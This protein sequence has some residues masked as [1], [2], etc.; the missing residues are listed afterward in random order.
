MLL[1]NNGMQTD[2]YDQ[3]NDNVAENTITYT[4]DTRNTAENTKRTT[5]NKNKRRKCG[6]IKVERCIKKP[7]F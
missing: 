7:S 3:N 4:T 1:N 2:F 6:R 5:N